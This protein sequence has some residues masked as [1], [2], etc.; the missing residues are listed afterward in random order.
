MQA[1]RITH[2]FG[3]TRDIS[4]TQE[5]SCHTSK[6]S[7]NIPLHIIS[8][9]IQTLVSHHRIHEIT[10]TLHQ[11][12]VTC[13]ALQGTCW[14]ICNSWEVG[15]YQIFHSGKK[16]GMQHKHAGVMLLIHKSLLKNRTCH[17]HEIDQG[18]AI[19]VR[20]TDRFLDLTFASVYIP[21][22][23]SKQSANCW[24]L[25]HKF[26]RSLPKR[27]IPVLCMDTNAH[28]DFTR[29]G[30]GWSCTNAKSRTHTNM[31]GEQLT[32]LIHDH[33][34]FVADTACSFNPNHSMGFKFPWTHRAPD[35]NTASYIDHILI[36]RKLHANISNDGGPDYKNQTQL[37]NE[38]N[39]IDHLPVTIHL[40]LPFQWHKP[41][42]KHVPKWDQNKLTQI[43]DQWEIHQKNKM[44]KQPVQTNSKLIEEAELLRERLQTKMEK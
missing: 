11:N 29:Q 6:R 42:P 41:Q 15:H 40:N 23:E 34:L 39:N 35:G 13:L 21:T 31:N 37:I 16:S 36:P 2:F 20:L 33:G 28:V 4:E 44:V 7:K 1:S 12:K 10:K 30:T 24:A 26:M 19:A 32:D 14:S 5:P 43:A 38:G 3:P 8:F 27:T 18:R 25:I 9:N 17:V 22:E